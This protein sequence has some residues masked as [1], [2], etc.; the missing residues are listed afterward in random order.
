MM[1][2]WC[3]S[4]HNIHRNWSHHL[5]RLPP[6]IFRSGYGKL[7][8]YTYLQ[9]VPFST[10]VGNFT[11]GTENRHSTCCLH[12]YRQSVTLNC[13]SDNSDGEYSSDS[14]KKKSDDTKNR[15]GGGAG[16]GGG[17]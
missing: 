17:G 3:R 15:D 7:Y 9:P 6:I 1:P 12:Q 10:Y 14:S 5:Y 13:K 11:S 8:G 16:C 4:L 2:T